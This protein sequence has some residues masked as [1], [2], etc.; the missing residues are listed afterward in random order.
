MKIVNP[1]N[2]LVASPP[3]QNLINECKATLLAKKEE[4]YARTLSLRKDFQS[5]DKSGDEVDLSS[6]ILA[7]NQIFSSIALL[8][9]QLLEIEYALARIEQGVYGICEETDEYIES[10]RLRAIPWTR[11]SIEGAEIREALEKRFA[12][13]SNP[14]S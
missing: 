8:Q 10:E 14:G 13:N 4:L 9:R 1:P 2:S 5:R 12:K 7:E 11:L 6:E 3:E